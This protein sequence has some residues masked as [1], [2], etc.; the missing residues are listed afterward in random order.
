MSLFVRFKNWFIRFTDDCYSLRL[1]IIIAAALLFASRQSQT[2]DAL[3]DIDPPQ[4]WFLLLLASLWPAFVFI[5]GRRICRQSF[6]APFLCASLFATVVFSFWGR[7]HAKRGWLLIIL[8]A[9]LLL[10]GP[11]FPL[12]R[13]ILKRC[14]LWRPGIAASIVGIFYLSFGFL[15]SLTTALGSM[16]TLFV[17]FWLLLAVAAVIARYARGVHL[18]SPALLAALLFGVLGWNNNHTIRVLPPDDVPPGS[19]LLP[20]ISYD[21]EAWLKSRPDRSLFSEVDPYP[22]YVISAEG[23]G[24]RAAYA[25]ALAL[26]RLQD[27]CPRFADHVYCIS[28]VSGGSIGAALFLAL[29]KVLGDGPNDRGGFGG[30]TYEEFVDR[31]FQQDF[32]APV[33]ASGLS[34]DPLQQL[35]PVHLPAFEDRAVALEKAFE[36]AWERLELGPNPFKA[37]F[38]ALHNAQPWVPRIVFN[39]T[40][41]ETGTRTLIADVAIDGFDHK[42]LSMLELNDINPRLST[43][44]VLGARFPIVSPAGVLRFHLRGEEKQISRSFVD[45]GYVDNTGIQ[46]LRFLLHFLNF[47]DQPLD[48]IPVCIRYADAPEHPVGGPAK[49]QYYNE[50]APFEGWSELLTPLL[51]WQ[52]ILSRSNSFLYQDLI[53]DW[54]LSGSLGAGAPTDIVIHDPE[55]KLPLGWVISP[56]ARDRVR[57]QLVVSKGL[58]RK[59]HAVRIDDFDGTA[60]T[61]EQ[62]RELVQLGGRT[63]G[64]LLF[65]VPIEEPSWGGGNYERPN[66]LMLGSLVHEV[67]DDCFL[68][69]KGEM[70]PREP[71]GFALTYDWVDSVRAARKTAGS[72]LAAGQICDQ[73]LRIFDRL[74]PKDKRDPRDHYEKD[75]QRLILQEAASVPGIPPDAVQQ[76]VSRAVRLDEHA[77]ELQR[78]E[79]SRRPNW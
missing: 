40:N 1:L 79:V 22:V 73:Y 27:Q 71:L 62:E 39:T 59:R 29:R 56:S 50:R 47:S 52:N 74:E 25:T 7:T 8:P 68:S 4:R 21:F 77:E 11:A 70:V 64:Q 30:R 75:L 35:L 42:Q 69:T 46:T 54:A 78:D 3:L 34:V 53:N 55:K 18:C 76:L 12:L 63:S 24:I 28:S 17:M 48:L 15:P 57:N 72:W 60:W 58:P 38:F 43:A 44:A 26:A 6:C 2:Q 19:D 65:G 37:S 67:A 36:A 23:G 45:G 10:L 31:F 33:I 49:R 14:S 20:R 13:R 16:G 9:S 61:V 5:C 32:L 51:A 41:V 66:A